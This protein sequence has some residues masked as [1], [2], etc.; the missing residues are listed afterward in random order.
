MKKLLL[1]FALALLPYTVQAQDS[2]NNW[3]EVDVTV[4]DEID[5]DFAPRM[6]GAIINFVGKKGIGAFLGEGN[7]IGPILM[8]QVFHQKAG[9]LTFSGYTLVSSDVSGIS[10]GESIFN[11]GTFGLEPRIAWDKVPGLE[12]GLGLFS[13]RFEEGEKAKWGGY[14][15]AVFRP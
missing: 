6:T 4:F 10:E 7:A 8:A 11:N 14:V 9:A 13:W 3:T 12:L 5:G 15:K 2:T 1:V